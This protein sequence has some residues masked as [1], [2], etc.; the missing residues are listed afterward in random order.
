MKFEI[1]NKYVLGLASWLNELQLEGGFSRARTELVNLL[2]AKFRKIEEQRIE[3]IKK[4]AK[5]DEKGELEL[6]EGKPEIEDNRKFMSDINAL[7][8]KKCTVQISDKDFALLKTIVLN[9]SYLFGP[10]EGDSPE[11]KQAKLRQANDY[12][13]WCKSFESVDN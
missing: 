13:K 6:K 5:K 2:S 3:I 12:N 1:E 11:E 7:Y 9:T 8:V 10:K 4:H